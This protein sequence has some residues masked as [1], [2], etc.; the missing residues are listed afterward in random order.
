MDFLKALFGD[1]ALSFDELANAINAHN[2][3]EANKDNQIKIGNLGGGEY[4]G[5]AKY[6]SLEALLNGKKTELDSANQ[7]IEELKKGTKGNDAL[8]SKVTAYET[9]VEQLKAENEKIRLDAAVKV[10][11]LEAKAND[12][13]YLTFKLTA[14]GTKLELDENGNIKGIA[15]KIADLK[16]KFPTQFE[17]GGGNGRKVDTLPLPKPDDNNTLTKAELLKKPYA[18][19]QKFYEENPDAYNEIM[20]N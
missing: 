4:V 14:D 12:I 3:N 11:L 17:T 1:K 10:A 20:N 18:E 19:R 2:G 8:Q 6:D 7:L 5:K 15:D 16:T 13:D 9:Q